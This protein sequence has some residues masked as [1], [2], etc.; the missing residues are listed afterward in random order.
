MLRN[1]FRLLTQSK[2]V[3]CELVHNSEQSMAWIWLPVRLKKCTAMRWFEEIGRRKKHK[4]NMRCCFKYKHEGVVIGI[5]KIIVTWWKIKPVILILL[6]IGYIV[7]E[8]T[9][10]LNYFQSKQLYGIRT[11]FVGMFC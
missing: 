9:F 3:F 4:G 11:V 2:N 5:I 10:I 6:L 7:L 8:I 1:L